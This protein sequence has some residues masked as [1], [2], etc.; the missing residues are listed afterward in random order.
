VAGRVLNELQQRLPQEILASPNGYTFNPSE[1]QLT[2]QHS[3]PRPH[4]VRTLEGEPVEL[5]DL[6]EGRP[7]ASLRVREKQQVVHPS[8]HLLRGD[9]D[10]LEGLP[11]GIAL[12]RSLEAQ[13]SLTQHERKRRFDLVG[14][15]P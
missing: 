12:P 6:V 1:L 5:D 3:S 11:V 4:E 13:V 15:L 9:P 8:P 2:L 7:V 10:S 14:G